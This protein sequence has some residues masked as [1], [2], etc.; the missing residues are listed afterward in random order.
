MNNPIQGLIHITGEPD[1]GKTTLALST[2]FAP[3]E[4]CF[5]DDDLKTQAIA[6]MLAEQGTPFGAYFNLTKLSL[7]MREIDFHNLVLRLIEEQPKNKFKAL[8]IPNKFKYSAL[9]KFS[10]FKNFLRYLNDLRGKLEYKK[11]KTP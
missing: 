10:M 4:I 5:F 2:G 6:G 1:T 7:G 11:E 3:A 9:L 8:I